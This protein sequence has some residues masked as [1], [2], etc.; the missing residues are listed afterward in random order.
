MSDFRVLME[1]PGCSCLFEH[2]GV[3]QCDCSPGVPFVPARIYHAYPTQQSRQANIDPADNAKE[4]ERLQ[5]RLDESIRREVQ[6]EARVAELQ[7]KTFARFH[8][9]ECWVWAGDG[10]D[11]L[12]TL[13]CPVV[14]APADLLALIG[15]GQQAGP[16]L[17]GTI[18]GGDATQNTINVS[19]THPVPWADFPMGSAVTLASGGSQ[20]GGAGEPSIASRELT[21]IAASLQQLCENELRGKAASSVREVWRQLSDVLR[22]QSHPRNAEAGPHGRDG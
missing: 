19:L 6:L 16:V 22:L 3:S 20:G 13:V 12:E 10:S 11:N 8:E 21:D 1:C 2:P 15:T 14:I 4:V 9:D 7:R 5:R 18:C 17:S